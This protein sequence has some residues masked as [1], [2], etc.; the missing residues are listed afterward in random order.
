M[1]CKHYLCGDAMSMIS[2]YLPFAFVIAVV[3]VL[4]A[5][6]RSNISFAVVILS[7]TAYSLS[8]RTIYV[9]GLLGNFEVHIIMSFFM[10]S[11]I[12]F[13]AWT[14]FLKILFP[15][16]FIYLVLY[17]DS[18]MSTL[19]LLTTFCSYVIFIGLFLNMIS[20]STVTGVRRFL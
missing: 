18:P 3:I 17:D 6:H 20:D 12:Y 1:I 13:Y 11:M 14:F 9:N 15:S 5:I 4:D 8:K 16:H 19:A 2:K 10:L 7:M